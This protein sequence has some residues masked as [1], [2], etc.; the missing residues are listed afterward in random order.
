MGIENYYEQS[1]IATMEKVILAENITIKALDVPI[2]GKFYMP[3]VQPTTKRYDS[4]G[5]MVKASTTNIGGA[6]TSNYIDLLIPAHLILPFTKPT[7]KEITVPKVGKIKVLA[8][9]GGSIPS[10]TEFIVEYLG[11]EKKL[12]KIIIV[13]V[14]PK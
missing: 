6:K 3:V 4:N 5:K 1:S 14:I 7:I 11:G 10:G 12:D 2:K 8:T 9:T 13:G